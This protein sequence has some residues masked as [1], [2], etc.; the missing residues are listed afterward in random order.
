[1]QRRH[2]ITITVLVLILAAIGYYIGTQFL[3]AVESYM[4]RTTAT[5]IETMGE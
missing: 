3:R 1:M 2:R 5:T 4:E